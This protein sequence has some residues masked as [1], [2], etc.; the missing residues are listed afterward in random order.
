MRTSAR[1]TRTTASAS[2]RATHASDLIEGHGD[3]VDVERND[4]TRAADV[5]LGVF[6]TKARVSRNYAANNSGSGIELFE[7]GA[8]VARNTANDNGEWGIKGVLGTIDGGKQPRARQR[9][10]GAVPERHLPPL[11]PFALGRC[12]R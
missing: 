10:A 9:R 3:R 6:D 4:V 7:P 2:A 1:A 11:L 8:R 5:G 12:G